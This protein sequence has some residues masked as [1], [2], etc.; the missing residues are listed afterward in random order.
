M[1]IQNKFWLGV[2]GLLLSAGVAN[3]QNADVAAE[4][5]S[6]AILFKVHDISP[7]KGGIDGEVTSCEFYVTFYNRSKKDIANA[8]VDLS[9]MDDSLSDLIA[10]EQKDSTERNKKGEKVE[11]NFSYTQK[12][13]PPQLSVSVKVPP[14]KPYKQMTTKQSLDTDRCYVLMNPLSMNVKSCSIKQTE[15]T[16]FYGDEN[17]SNMFHFVSQD[18]PEYYMDFQPIS[19]ST[20]QNVDMKER[21]NQERAVEE[22]YRKTVRDMDSLSRALSEIR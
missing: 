11:A 3:A 22:Q 13:N 10:A 5:E 16:S 21:A 17:C 18:N 15:N 8:Q 19:F 6:E 4:E 1:K 12:L 9:W 7:I 20:Q 14:L 2:A